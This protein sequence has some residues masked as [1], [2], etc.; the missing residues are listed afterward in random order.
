[1][2]R[3]FQTDVSTFPG[4]EMQNV[5]KKIIKDKTTNEIEKNGN[6]IFV[7]FFLPPLFEY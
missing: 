4:T 7:K 1:V 5:N 6:L 3:H 2:G